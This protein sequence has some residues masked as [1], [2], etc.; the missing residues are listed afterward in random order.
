MSGSVTMYTTP[1]CGYCHRLK[2]Q[3]DREGIAFEVVDI[4]QQPEAAEI[5]ESRQQRQPDR[6]DAGVRRRHRRRRTPRSPRSRTSWP[7][8]R[9]ERARCAAHH[10]PGSGP[11][12]QCSTSDR[13]IETPPGSTSVPA[14]ASSLIWSRVNHRASSISSSVDLDLVGRRPAEEAEHQAGGQRPR[15]VAEVGHLAD[16]HAGLLGDLAAYGVL[17]RLARLAGSRPASSSGRP[18]RRPDARAADAR[19][20]TPGSPRVIAMITAGSVRG[21]WRRWHVDARE[22]VAR[23]PH[24]EPAP[25]ARAVSRDEEPLREPD[26]VEDQRRLLDRVAGQ[27]RQEPAEPDPLVLRPRRPGR[28]RARTTP[29]RRAR[30][31]ARACPSPG[32]SCR[33]HPVR[34]LVDGPDAGAGR[35][36]AP[37]TP[38]RPTLRRATPRRRGAPRPGR[39]GLRPARRGDTSRLAG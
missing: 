28:G 20:S 5:V 30:P 32:A 35:R 36:R 16:H 23:H 7:R 1:W 17:E 27:V 10:E 29:A 33:R 38:G 26:R 3:L 37:A 13:E 6:P 15:L 19:P 39:V 11:P 18:A 8:W 25:A 34:S 31:A 14:S 24:L 22:L 21:N 4:E 12:Y 9:P 2:G